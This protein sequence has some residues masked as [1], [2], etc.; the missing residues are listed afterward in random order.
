[1]KLP[2]LTCLS[3]LTKLTELTLSDK[4]NRHSLEGLQ[5]LA[6]LSRLRYPLLHLLANPPTTSAS[7]LSTRQLGPNLWDLIKLVL[8]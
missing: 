4:H 6:T 7:I 2:S 8:P 3:A 1:M 5:H